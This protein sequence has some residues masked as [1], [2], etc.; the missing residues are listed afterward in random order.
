MSAFLLYVFLR[1]DR[2]MSFTVLLSCLV[3]AL[4]RLAGLVSSEVYT[5]GVLA[6]I[7]FDVAWRRGYLR[8]VL[9]ERTEKLLRRSR[10]HFLIAF[11]GHVR[12]VVAGARL[13]VKAGVNRVILFV[14]TTIGMGHA[15]R[16]TA[17]S[18]NK[19]ATDDRKK[20]LDALPPAPHVS[21][22]PWL[23]ERVAKL[24][25]S[26]ACLIEEMRSV[27]RESL[28]IKEELAGLKQELAAAKHEIR[29]AARESGGEGARTREG[30]GRNA[31]A[32]PV[33]AEV[34]R[35]VTV[36]KGEVARAH[37]AVVDLGNAMKGDE[38]RARD[39]NAL[40]NQ[41]YTEL[42]KFQK[43]VE[44]QEASRAKELVQLRAELDSWRGGISPAGAQPRRAATPR[45]SN[46]PDNH[47]SSSPAG[48]EECAV[49]L[50]P[51]AHSIMLYPCCHTLCS[52]CVAQFK[53]RQCPTCREEVAQYL[54]AASGESTTAS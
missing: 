37:K 46:P 40:R 1:L 48:P 10:N 50:E 23:D 4:V 45:S 28:V 51:A 49:C 19:N 30:G 12:A 42:D 11:E 41:V 35:E 8:D 16:P 6:N 7:V 21:W 9:P 15:G 52:V 26:S 31:D 53:F 34:L 18:N 13:S 47:A 44:V 22:N 20:N 39:L 5:G 29:A 24:E 38:W 54:D 43:A 17:T 25:R 2:V 33:S 3:L 32:R 27:T 36:L 14:K